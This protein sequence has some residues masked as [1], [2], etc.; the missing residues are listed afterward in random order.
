VKITT[1]KKGTCHECGKHGHGVLFHIQN[2]KTTEAFLC[3][4]HFRLNTEVLMEAGVVRRHPR[5]VGFTLMSPHADLPPEAGETMSGAR[6]SGRGE[7]AGRSEGESI[8]ISR[9]R[10]WSRARSETWSESDGEADDMAP[11]GA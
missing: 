2:D 6:W 7:T 8:G 3:W 10:T 5:P 11:V 9:S 1:T 4:E